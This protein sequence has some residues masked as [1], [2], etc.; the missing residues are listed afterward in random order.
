LVLFPSSSCKII[1]KHGVCRGCTLGKH[2]KVSFPSNEHRSKVILDL[3]HS[4]VCGPMSVAS[5]T[6]SMYYV[7]FI[8]DFSRKTWIYF[9]K[10]KDEVFRRFQEFK[11]LVKNQTGK[12]IKLLRS[13]SGGEYTSKDFKGFCKELGIKRELTFSYNPNRMGLHSRRNDPS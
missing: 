9:L 13:D 12:K 2:A 1:E 8:D 7:S 6:R 4:D 10:T 5:I 11:A 3:V